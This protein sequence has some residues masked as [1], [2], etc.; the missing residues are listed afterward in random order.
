MRGG[1][2]YYGGGALDSQSSGGYYWSRSPNNATNGYGLHF[3]SV[4][5]SPQTPYARGYGFAL[6]CLER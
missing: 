2:Y 6:R 1:D 3:S 4:R 5:V